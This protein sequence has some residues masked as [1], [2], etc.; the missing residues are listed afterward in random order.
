MSLTN[1]KLLRNDSERKT[2]G[3][4]DF[5]IN[6]IFYDE[7]NGGIDTSIEVL[8]NDGILMPRT[9]TLQF[10]RNMETN[11]YVFLGEGLLTTCEIMIGEHGYSVLE[12]LD[13]CINKFR[14][15]I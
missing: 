2:I 10:K 13:L 12:C 15:N 14:E 8:W 4:G 1:F 7:V 6:Y 9:T 11:L 5:K 3:R